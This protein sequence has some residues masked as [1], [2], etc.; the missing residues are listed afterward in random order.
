MV[1]FE[2]RRAEHCECECGDIADISKYVIFH[3]FTSDVCMVHVC[4]E[5]RMD[6]MCMFVCICV[7]GCMLC[8][9]SCYVLCFV[10]CFVMVL[11][12]CV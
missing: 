1:S 10:L 9:V 3:V 6:D 2:K 5:D 8:V 4:V 11:V 12:V 7:C